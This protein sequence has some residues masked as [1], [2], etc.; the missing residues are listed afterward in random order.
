MWVIILYT[1]IVG[2]GKIGDGY[3]HLFKLNFGYK[4][5]SR[6]SD[7][8]THDQICSYSHLDQSLQVSCIVLH[9]Q[10]LM[11]LLIDCH[12]VIEAMINATL[13]RI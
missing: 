6:I 7:A 12:I 13:E 2:I 4:F 9:M 1:T 10:L 11:S 3:R 5:D 8:I